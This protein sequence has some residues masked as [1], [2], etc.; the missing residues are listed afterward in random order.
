MH[1]SVSD[2]VVFRYEIQTKIQKSYAAVLFINFDPDSY[3]VAT[4]HL[5]I[6]ETISA[7]VVITE[8]EQYSHRKERRRVEND[9]LTSWV[10]DEIDPQGEANI[11]IFPDLNLEVI[12]F[13]FVKSTSFNFG[14]IEQP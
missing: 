8:L 1:A 13:D 3:R 4:M 6:N 14:H 9:D 7:D 11:L 2:S 12:Y 10:T 5:V